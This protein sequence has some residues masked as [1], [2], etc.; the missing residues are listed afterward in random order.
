V[1]V[2]AIVD[3]LPTF[4]RTSTLQLFLV[5][6]KQNVLGFLRGYFQFIPHRQWPLAARE[7]HAN[8]EK[9]SERSTSRNY[10]P[11]CTKGFR[12]SRFTG[13]R[14]IIHV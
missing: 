7:S 12:H 14:R 9:R 13:I 4:R 3:V 2:V 5:A 11:D 10:H 8:E 6:A 1:K